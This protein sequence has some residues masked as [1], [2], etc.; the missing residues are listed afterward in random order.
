M[1]TTTATT[2]ITPTTCSTPGTTPAAVRRRGRAGVLL[3]TAV[4]LFASVATIAIGGDT[5]T[6]A[7]SS[8]KLKIVVVDTDG[9]PHAGA[10]ALA[11]PYLVDPSEG[12]R[13]D[14]SAGGVAATT[15]ERGGA[16]LHVDPERTYDVFAFVADPE[17]AWAC[18]GFV[19]NG[20][21]LYFGDRVTGVGAELP[22]KVTLTVPE[23]TPYDCVEVRVQTGAGVPLP[24]AGFIVCAREPGSAACIGEQFPYLGP[25]DVKRMVV[26]PGLVYD[27]QA[28][29]AN[30][31]WPCGFTN[32]DGTVFHFSERVTRTADELLPG[33]TLTI[34]E[35]APT[36]C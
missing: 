9:D 33:L 14:C 3:P 21:E 24:Q 35:P 12:G 4:A 20:Q 23:P 2:S 16:V 15:D 7:H 5:A 18:P 6:A 17:P 31:G 22:R 32:T 25:G 27:V 1:D 34:V 30:I 26:E 29:V 36:D 8:T 28:Y 19:F 10:T 13:A 11:C